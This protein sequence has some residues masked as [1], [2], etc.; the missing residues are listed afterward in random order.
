M[1]TF[2]TETAIRILNKQ[3]KAIL[4]HFSDEQICYQICHKLVDCGLT[5][6]WPE[7]DDEMCAVISNMTLSDFVDFILKIGNELQDKLAEKELE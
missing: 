4:E 6:T 7:D 5:E 2:I 3:N 1:L